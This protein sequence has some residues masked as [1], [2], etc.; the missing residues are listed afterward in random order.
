M[1]HSMTTLP[2]IQNQQLDARYMDPQHLPEGVAFSLFSLE[3][4]Q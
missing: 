4:E 2:D 1:D 3:G